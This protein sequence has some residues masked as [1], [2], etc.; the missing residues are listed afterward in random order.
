MAVPSLHRWLLAVGL[1]SASLASVAQMPG[2]PTGMPGMP[3]GGPPV[4][5]PHH[6]PAKLPD[7]TLPFTP[8]T[9]QWTP[10]PSGAGEFLLTRAEDCFPALKVGGRTV[11]GTPLGLQVVQGGQ[12]SLH[13]TLYGKPL[14]VI[15]EAEGLLWVQEI[16]G[17]LYAL[18]PETLAITHAYPTVHGQCVAINASGF[19]CL[20]TF[21]HAL[22]IPADNDPAAYAVIHYDR[23]GK[24]CRRFA[25]DGTAL[26]KK[27]TI[28]WVAA[29][30]DALWL[31]VHPDYRETCGMHDYGPKRLYRL[32]FIKGTLRQIKQPVAAMVSPMSMQPDSLLWAVGS[33]EENIVAVMRL[34]KHTLASTRVGKIPEKY[35]SGG[36]LLCD[37]VVWGWTRADFSSTTP[38]S[39]AAF[40]ATDC[41]RIP[42]EQ[43]G[44]PPDDVMKACQQSCFLVPP[45]R[46]IAV[47]AERAWL[48]SSDQR[49]LTEVRDTGEVLRRDLSALSGPISHIMPRTTLPGRLMLRVSN[50]DYQVLQVTAGE[51]SAH[52]LFLGDVDYDPIC[53]RSGGRYWL[54]GREKLFTADTE[55]TLREIEL[56][57]GKMPERILPIGDDA[58]LCYRDALYRVTGR[59]GEL[60]EI[61]SWATQ[62][63]QGLRHLGIRYVLGMR[64]DRLFLYSGYSPDDP[65][66]L[67]L[68]YDLPQDRWQQVELPQSY[69]PIPG[70]QPYVYAEQKL[71]TVDERGVTPVGTLPSE[72]MSPLGGTTRYLYVD[73]SVGIC[74]L[75]W[76]AVLG[77]EAN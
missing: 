31:L 32:D 65:H 8:A 39:Y 59:T 33:E 57:G 77:K 44:P 3:P 48:L 60:H 6:D 15:D 14:L 24:E 73:T 41:R 20:D 52:R 35:A 43:V 63:P 26:R 46:V 71:Y 19:W 58:L 76:S 64:G 42:L 61:T 75:P 36:L 18:D 5:R 10:A 62:V 47:D 50:A 49:T 53:E 54:R 1:L 4:V 45:Q 13:P 7:I 23:T 72:G 17:G 68:I 29:D 11:I 27:D 51:T 67:L 12:L 2:F 37:G 56:P 9:V 22:N 28:A 30:D 34:D 74:R 69:R 66:T 70:A 38:S 25:T 16:N 40:S 55:F 21:E